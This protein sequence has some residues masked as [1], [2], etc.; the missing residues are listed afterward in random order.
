MVQPRVSGSPP[1]GQKRT[2]LPGGGAG[3][4]PGGAPM[5]SASRSLSLAGAGSS[6]SK[7][8]MRESVLGQQALE[9]RRRRLQELYSEL[10]GQ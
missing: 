2:W 9:Q 6:G 1:G 8:A 7:E 5:P 3:G 4:K 10:K